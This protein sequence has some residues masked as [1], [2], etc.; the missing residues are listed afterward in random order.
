[1]FNYCAEDNERLLIRARPLSQNI[2]DWNIPDLGN[3]WNGSPDSRGLLR[4]ER[5]WLAGFER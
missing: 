3:S 4:G 2:E 1:M 5:L